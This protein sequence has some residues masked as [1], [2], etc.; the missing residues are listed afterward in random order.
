M[1]K[2][3]ELAALIGSGQAQGDKNLIIN[4]KF[5]IFQ[6]GTGATTVNGNDV[7]AADRFKGWANG[8]GT[9][10]VEQSTDVPN[11]EFTQQQPLGITYTNTQ[12][13][14]QTHGKRKPL[15]FRLAIQQALGTRLTEM[16]CG[17]IGALVLGLIIKELLVR[18]RQEKSGKHLIKPLG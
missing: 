17:Y 7:F 18:G 5:S 13:H 9:Y 2:A 12:F 6:R 16:A 3:A 11:N 10:T 4:G 8:G 1:S 15:R 14:L